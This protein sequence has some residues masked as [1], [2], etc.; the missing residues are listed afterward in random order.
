[1][2]NSPAL[3]FRSLSIKMNTPVAWQIREAF[4]AYQLYSK[5]EN[6]PLP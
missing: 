6:H 3:P 2:S 4:Q 5:Q 1:M